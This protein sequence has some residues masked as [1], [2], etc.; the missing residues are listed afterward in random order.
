M[1][2]KKLGEITYKYYYKLMQYVVTHTCIECRSK[3]LSLVQVKLETV[4][5]CASGM[6]AD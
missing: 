6:T 5:I 3:G 1:L 2:K 4:I